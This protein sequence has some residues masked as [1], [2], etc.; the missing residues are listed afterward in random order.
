[1]NKVEKIIYDLVKSMPWLKYLIRNIYQSLFDL[2]P[3]KKEFFLHPLE[4]RQNYFFGFH[5][6]SPFS[7]DNKKV[8]ANELN[9]P[10]RMPKPEDC[11]GMGYFKF[12][13][14]KLLSFQKIG[15]SLS[16]NYHKGCRLQWVDNDHV[17]YNTVKS[18]NLVSKVVNIENL[19]EKIID[20]P[21]DSVSSDGQL[22]TSFSYERLEKLMPGY[23]YNYMDNA[24]LDQNAPSETGLF[25]IDLKENTRTLIVSLKDLASEMAQ[26]DSK[27]LDF[28]HYVTHSDFSFN[29]RY[30]SFLHRWVADDVL[31]RKTRLVIFDLVENSFFSLPTEGMVSH[32]VWN[33]NNQIIAFC[34]IKGIDCHCLFDIPQINKFKTVSENHLN[35]DGHQS[36]ITDQIFITDTYPDRHRMAKLFKVNITTGASQLLASVYS[37]KKFQTRNFQKHIACDLHPRVSPDQKYVC[38]DSIRMGVRSFC[39]ME[40]NNSE[41]N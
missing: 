24:Y 10:L 12:E 21:I 2:L 38:F 31:N 35:S 3:R 28:Q 4:Y 26:K 39:I 22:A 29:K 6:K 19:A 40:L 16:W 8:L 13:N 11:L 36:F 34:R 20:A 7:K 15:E 5:D 33:K 14:G 18:G 32:Y 9:I 17:I 23:G 1:M 37:P 30:V 27:F 25:V 41:F